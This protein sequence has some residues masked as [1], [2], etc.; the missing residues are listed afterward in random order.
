MGGPMS[1]P[2]RVSTTGIHAK[3][4]NIGNIVVLPENHNR[5]EDVGDVVKITDMAAPIDYGP[6]VFAYA[7]PST[8]EH[9]G[10][11]I[12]EDGDELEVVENEADFTNPD[13]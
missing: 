5:P 10:L 12:A 6:Y 11:Y 1:S 9:E 4:L 8:D 13:Q 7:D 2:E 3:S